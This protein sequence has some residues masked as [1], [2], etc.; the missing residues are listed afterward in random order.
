MAKDARAAPKA[1]TDLQLRIADLERELKFK[2]R[3][4]EELK[5]EL[6]EQRE[7]VRRFEE[8]AQEDAE[9]LEDF[10]LTFGLVLNDNGEWTNGEANAEHDRVVEKYS[11]LI[12]RYNKLV[13]RFNRNIARVNPVG[14]PLAASEEQQAQIIRHHKAG[15]SS[16]WIAEEMNLSWRTV[17]T[18]TG[19]HDGTDRT[20][21]QRR[22]K[23]GLE[24]KI[25]DWRITSRKRLPKAATAHLEKGRKLIKEA[26]G[27]APK[28]AA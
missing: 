28:G 13:G 17:T 4:I 18:V 9:Y 15:K 1:Q 14:R 10:I 20:T 3:R 8:H 25:K 22:L 24:P 27:L 26:K 6:D 5:L 21:A 12:A 16:R 2:D 7:L 23:L 11:D 19:K